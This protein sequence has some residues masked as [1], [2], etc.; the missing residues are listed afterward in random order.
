M[1]FFGNLRN[2]ISP[3]PNEYQIHNSDMN[4]NS[5]I[6]HKRN[7]PTSVNR[8]KYINQHLPLSYT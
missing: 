4:H 1:R 7:I 8:K 2:Y 6:N 3:R 5:D